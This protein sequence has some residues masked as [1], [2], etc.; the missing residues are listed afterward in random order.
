[1]TFLQ[2]AAAAA[3]AAADDDDDVF[4][5]VVAPMRG[6]EAIV[7]TQTTKLKKLLHG[8]MAVLSGLAQQLTQPSTYTTTT[9]EQFLAK[10]D[11][12]VGK[13]RWILFSG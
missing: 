3:A 10:V 6:L 5:E 9:L 8:S 2:A 11:D 12:V 1:M 4:R 7:H 13:N